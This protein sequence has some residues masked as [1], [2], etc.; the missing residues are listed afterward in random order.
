M[1]LKKI[2]RIVV[3]VTIAIVTLVCSS[4]LVYADPIDGVEPDYNT[5]QVEENTGDFEEEY[6]EETWEEPWSEPEVVEDETVW[7]ETTAPPTTTAPPETE[8]ES[9][10]EYYYEEETE[11]ETYAETEGTS[12]TLPFANVIEEATAALVVDDT[13]EPGD[14]TYGIASWICVIAGIIVIMVVLISNKTQYHTGGGKYRYDE[15][16]RITGQKRLL[17]DDYYNRR[18]AQSYYKGTRR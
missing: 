1:K 11:A 3:I 13:R 15:G 14:F 7:T 5:P 4:A 17:N 6:T 10:E 8:P 18:N 9:S 2:G 12:Y 16:D